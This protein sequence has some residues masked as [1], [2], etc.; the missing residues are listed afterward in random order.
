MPIEEYR[1]LY[2]GTTKSH[3]NIYLGRDSANAAKYLYEEAGIECEIEKVDADDIRFSIDDF[4]YLVSIGA[5]VFKPDWQDMIVDDIDKL[6]DGYRIMNMYDFKVQKH[7]PQSFSYDNIRKKGHVGIMYNKNEKITIFVT[8]DKLPEFS[9]SIFTCTEWENIVDYS[10]EQI[11][12]KIIEHNSRNV[13]DGM[14]PV[15]NLIQLFDKKRYDREDLYEK[16]KA[17][18]TLYIQ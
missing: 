7:E 15:I 5:T 11:D 17:F 8:H 18:E 13:D 4:S 12:P 1:R 6:V 3:M 9:D 14:D 10:P 2:V 16:I